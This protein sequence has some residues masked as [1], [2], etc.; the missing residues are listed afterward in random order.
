MLLL[1]LLKLHLPQLLTGQYHTVKV[2]RAGA[3]AIVLLASSGKRCQI[4]ARALLPRSTLP[5]EPLYCNSRRLHVVHALGTR[6][7]DSDLAQNET[8]IG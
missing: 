7:G 1:L 4:I 3:R 5:K 2:L 8:E 6:L